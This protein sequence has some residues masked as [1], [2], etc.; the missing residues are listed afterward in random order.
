MKKFLLAIFLCLP[1]LVM[2]QGNK[3]KETAVPQSVL[4]T[5]ERTYSAYKVKTWYQLPGQ[6]IADI[7]V[8]G[9][10]GRSYFTASGDWQYSEFPVTKSNS[11]TRMQTY[12]DTSYPGY[13]IKEIVMVEEMSGDAYYN[14]VIGEINAKSSRTYTMRFDTR[15]NLQ[16]AGGAPDPAV[17]KREYAARKGGDDAVKS[18]KERA[19]EQ[20]EAK[21]T[22]RRGK[23]QVDEPA[24]D[25]VKPTPAIAAAFEKKFPKSRLKVA[26]EW[27]VRLNA[28][29]ADEMVAYFTNAQGVRMEAVFDSETEKLKCVGKH[30]AEERYTSAIVKYIEEKFS[31][32]NFRYE[33]MVVYEYDSK[34]RD[35]ETQ[36][37]PKQY[38]YAVISE[39]GSRSRGSLTFTRMEFDHAG[40][41][42]GLLAQPLDKLDVDNKSKK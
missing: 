7:I 31:D 18:K 32:R 37:K 2:A 11:P 30:L 6:Y 19:K 3:I 13:R 5:L 16:N 39:R 1:L 12:F 23:P 14:M 34:Y 26:P 10:A 36:K 9:Q 4:L 17:A 38:T 27:V 29:G 42:T 20:A 8:D 40:N 41:F 35:P 15:G 25:V 28:K 21:E 24:P 22:R 33:K